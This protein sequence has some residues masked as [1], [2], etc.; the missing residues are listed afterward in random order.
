M[1]RKQPHQMLPRHTS[2]QRYAPELHEQLT[3]EH[4]AQT[5]PPT[6]DPVFP[7]PRYILTNPSP[8]PESK[9]IFFT[10]Y[11]HADNPSAAINFAHHVAE[12]L[13]IPIHWR[14]KHT[15]RELFMSLLSST[16]L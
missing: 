15:G 13:D 7:N 5:G 9:D 16:D 2:E 4:N 12:R 6:D 1:E 11:Y 10:M 3:D 14:D 8:N